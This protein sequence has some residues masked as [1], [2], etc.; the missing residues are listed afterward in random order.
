MTLDQANE[1]MKALDLAAAESKSSEWSTKLV[2]LSYMVSARLKNPLKVAGVAVALLLLIA[3][4][5]VANLFLARGGAR[6]R[7]TA[8]RS[9][10]GAG[11]VRL[12]REL[13]FE[14]LLVAGA[15]SALGIGFAA[16]VLDVVRRLRPEELRLLDSLHLDPRI[17]AAAVGAAV[18]TVLLFG[19]LPLLHR[20]RTRPGAVL[21][22]TI[23]DVG[24]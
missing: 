7:D 2:P 24:R 9:A 10:V 21:D 12:A 4:L 3:C 20:I 5:N 16:V 11:S 14:A 18:L 6:V 8:V 17:T 19:S 13:L 1:R 23:G 22:R 15:A